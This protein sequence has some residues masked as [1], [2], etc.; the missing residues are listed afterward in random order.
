MDEQTKNLIRDYIAKA[1]LDKALSTFSTWADQHGDSALK[2]NLFL[3]KSDYSALKSDENMG[4][5][6]SRD[7]DVRRNKIVKA[8]LSM[9]DDAE[10]AESE[11]KPVP[12]VQPVPKTPPA[13]SSNDMK[14]ILFMGANPPEVRSVQ[15]EIE[16]SRISTELSGK[17]N[18]PTEKF[19]SANQISKLIIKHKPYIV[20]FSGHGKNPES[21]EHGE[22]GAGMSR[23]VGRLPKDYGQ[24]GGIVTFSEDMRELK[25]VDDDVIDFLFSSAVN[26]LG[27]PIQV[28][29]FNSC[30]SESQAK[31]IGKYI[32][33]VIGTANAIKDDLAIAFSTG[34][35][36]GLAQGLSIEQ[37]YTSGR[38]DVV[39]KDFKAK[40]LIVLYKN[41][42]RQ[43]L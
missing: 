17:F 25:I 6:D 11:A 1:K 41:G 7:A 26:N 3:K 22:E 28:V 34:F 40:D 18:L 12:V 29:V 19:L 27:I 20:H 21:G 9:L 36:F 35:Y 43:K 15:L 2:N 32:P 39:V 31:V 8:V 30:Y 42:E 16:H 24:K 37:A 4:M 5:I 13:N 10:P 33:Y 23:A 38:M 14:T